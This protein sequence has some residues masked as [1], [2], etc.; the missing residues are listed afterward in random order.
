MNLLELRHVIELLDRH[1]SRA[2]VDRA[3]RSVGLDR[4]MFS[5][6]TGFLPYDSEAILFETVARAIGDRHLGARIGLEFDYA[7]YG[8][9]A[10]YV[11]GAPD[12]A[13]ALDRGR[14]ALSLTHPGSEIVIR[15]TEHH[16]VVGRNSEGFSVIGHR[17]LD[18]GALLV[19]GHVARHF[20]GNEWR[21]AWVEIPATCE[22]EAVT[23]GKLVDAPVRLGCRVPAISIPLA[24][25]AAR[26]PGPP[27][28]DRALSL[29][30]LGSL[31]GVKPVQT[32]QEAVVQVMNIMQIRAIPSEDAVARLLAIGPRTLQRALKAEGTSFRRIRDDF[33]EHRAQSLL[34]DTDMP[35]EKIGENL[36]YSEPK[37]FRRAFK[38]W[39][40][41]SPM[42]YRSA[43]QFQKN[44]A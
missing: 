2:I 29:E 18:E 25:L 41:V 35:I 11:L 34:R 4:A 22:S 5:G 43:G 8:A 21:P 3:L 12:L 38:R 7:A 19:I 17:H 24:D 1:A 39:T 23:L 16:L 30:E 28:S 27:R 14:R 20:L 44:T 42:G 40:G 9:Y 33:I 6:S 13:S 32:M 15:E 26:N 10:H 36:G 37:S 31:M